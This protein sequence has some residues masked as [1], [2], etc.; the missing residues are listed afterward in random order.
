MRVYRDEAWFASLKPKLDDF[1]A[2]IEKAKTGEFVLP[3]SS[4]KKKDVACMIADDTSSEEEK[5][6]PV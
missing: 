3:E 5:N 6:S 4:R 1:W 2:D